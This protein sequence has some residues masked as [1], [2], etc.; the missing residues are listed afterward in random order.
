VDSISDCIHSKS[1]KHVRTTGRQLTDIQRQLWS[2]CSAH[3]SN[4]QLH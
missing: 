3:Q 1:Q 4:W 2:H